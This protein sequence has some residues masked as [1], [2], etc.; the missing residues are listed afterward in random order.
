MANNE[1]NSASYMTRRIG[2]SQGVFQ[3]NGAG[4]AGR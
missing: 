4:N 3:Q 1:N 2:E